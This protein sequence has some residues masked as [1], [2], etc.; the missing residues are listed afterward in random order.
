[1]MARSAGRVDACVRWIRCSRCAGS[2]V[3]TAFAPPRWSARSRAG[4]TRASPPPPPLTLRRRAVRR[5]ALRD[6]RPRGVLRLPGHAPEVRAGRGRATREIDWPEVE[7]YEARV[8][9]APRDLVLL[10]GPEPSFRWRDVLPRRS[11]SSPRRIG[12]Q[13]VGHAR[14]AARRRPALAPGVDHRPAP[15]TR[16]WSS[17]SGCS[18]STLRGADRH[19]RR[20]ARRL[21]R[22]RGCR[23]RRCGPRSRT[24]SR[25]RRTRRARSAL[26][27]RL[28][29]AGRRDR[30]RVR[31]RGR[32]RRLRAPGHARGRDATPTSRPSSSASSARPTPRSG[33]P[34]PGRPAV[35]RRPRARVPALPAPK[36]S[37]RASDGARDDRVLPLSAR[38]PGRRSGSRTSSTPRRTASARSPG[39][40]CPRRPRARSR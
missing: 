34:R 32:R 6:D 17:G 16:R 24:T 26:L 40:G 3:P 12:V 5:H 15:P 11:S 7:I 23:R 9:R 30:R 29:G 8:P 19:R 14:R 20:P 37:G 31:A 13:I 27:R 1:M 4:T 28:E 18:R 35:R 36:G 22:T 10:A 25:S 38:R 2:A 39:P 21:R 33:Q